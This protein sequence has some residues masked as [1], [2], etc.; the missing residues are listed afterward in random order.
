VADLPTQPR[1]SVLPQLDAVGAFASFLCAI[2]CAAM[3]LLLS[4]VPF[5][6]IEL[7]ADH[8]L[9]RLFVGFAVVFGMIVIGAGYCRHKAWTVG[10]LYLVGV[11][12]LM[13]G[14]FGAVHGVGHAALLAF[15]GLMLGS[16]HAVNR[17][18]VRR[19]GCAV[20]LWAQ[21]YGVIRAR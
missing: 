10:A 19:H 18:A 21:L 7:L 1:D 16:A 13:V 15:G 17:R 2:H 5:A 11:L 20:N 12:S 6:G 3:P 4:T 9:E 14:A 8:R